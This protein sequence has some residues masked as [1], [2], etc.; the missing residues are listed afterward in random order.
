[1]SSLEDALALFH[2][3]CR[4][5]EEAAFVRARATGALDAK[6]ERARALLAP[7]RLCGLECGVDRTKGPAGACG[8]GPGLS[9]YL[10]F[11]HAGEEP[12]ISPTHAIL[13]TGCSY[14][15]SYCSEWDH[16]VEPTRALPTSPAELARAIERRRR[17]GALSVSWI[18]GEPLVNLPGILDVLAE[19]RV[20]VP[21]VWN[22]NM[23]AGPETFDI[24]SGVVDAYVADL[25]HGNDACARAVARAPRY[26]ETVVAAIERVSRE[27]FTIVRH[28]VLPGHVECC[29]IPA[30]ERLRG[31]A[32][33][34]N[35]MAQYRPTPNVTGTSL[36]RRPTEA[37]LRRAGEVLAALGLASEPPAPALPPPRGA[38]EIGPLRGGRESAE[39]TPFAS[40]IWVDD[41]GKV[42]IENLSPE[43]ARIL[44][45]LA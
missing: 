12:E 18:G 43:L 35:L 26:L 13:L 11:L 45:D 17:E 34:V 38:R 23:H 27:T 30:L 37:E 41:D 42:T 20:S 25:K 5:E 44:D 29:T 33:R 15:C 40:R 14:R 24:L 39:A 3:K 16:I 22:S 36:D 1:V 21:V 4:G 32:V 28:L 7:C 6:R 31:L 9:R 8:L 10:E 19:T 2:R